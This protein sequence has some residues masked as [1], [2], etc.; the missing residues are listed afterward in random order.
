M[1]QRLSSVL[2]LPALVAAGCAAQRTGV[3]L[4]TAEQEKLKR[5]F[6]GSEFALAQSLYTTDFFGDPNRLFAD[7]RPFESLSLFH[8][9]GTGTATGL[10]GPEIVP[11]G[12]MVRVVNIVPPIDPLVA[13]FDVPQSQLLP[14]AHTWVV[15]ERSEPGA[16]RMP[17]VLVLARRLPDADA[18]TEALQARLKSEQWVSQWL[19]QREPLV[20]A[21]INRKE[22]SVGMSWAEL[23]AALGEPKNSADFTPEGLL[24]FVA[25]YG[26]LQVK[27][28]GGRVRTIVS[29]KAEAMIA[30]RR[31][32]ESAEVARRAAQERLSEEEKRQRAERR[33]TGPRDLGL[34]VT[35]VDPQVAMALG[36]PGGQGCYVTGL[37]PDGEAVEAGLSANDVIIEVDNIPI[38]GADFFRRLVVTARPTQ[39]IDITFVRRTTRM[40]T[41]DIVG[42]LLTMTMMRPMSS[43]R[44]RPN[45][46]IRRLMT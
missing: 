39:K 44:S 32:R 3:G 7:P 13:A 37:E 30:Q 17:L 38:E 26:D 35:D 20:L 42:S 36:L 9:D 8:H 31:A 41:S 28:E 15:L 1:S 43:R 23:N 29:R 6:V 25:D 14:T 24:P 27:V 33:R 18:L 2:L 10:P 16:S 5:R 46:V 12:T 34:T 19:T 40:L 45:A 4:T 11:A 22:P 21:N